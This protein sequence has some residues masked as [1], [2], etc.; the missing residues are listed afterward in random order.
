MLLL[1]VLTA[2]S[3]SRALNKQCPLVPNSVKVVGMGGQGRGTVVKVV[4]PIFTH[5]SG[6]WIILGLYVDEAHVVLL[7]SFFERF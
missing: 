1:R 5:R 2:Q 4:T 3:K 6:V 7:L